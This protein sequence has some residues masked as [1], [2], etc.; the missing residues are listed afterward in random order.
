MFY[1]RIGRPF[2]PMSV[3]SAVSLHLKGGV[4]SLAWYQSGWFQDF[5][6]WAELRWLGHGV[7]LNT[8][9]EAHMELPVCPTHPFS[10][11]LCKTISELPRGLE[12]ISLSQGL[13]DEVL[14]IQKHLSI[15]R[16]RCTKDCLSKQ[17]INSRYHES[18]HL[19]LKLAKTLGSRQC[20]SS[21]SG[22]FAT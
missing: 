21:V 1:V 11:T 16:K 13:S 5:F 17:E 4:D 7:R 8:I 14:D 10:R 2:R 20:D 22:C 6:N 12:E 18:M 15:R 3:V 9:R 19:T